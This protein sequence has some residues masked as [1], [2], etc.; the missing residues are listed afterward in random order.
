MLHF[1]HKTSTNFTTSH[2]LHGE[3]LFCYLLIYLV[4]YFLTLYI[5]KRRRRWRAWFKWSANLIRQSTTSL[6]SYSVRS[7]VT[8]RRTDISWLETEAAILSV[9]AAKHHRY[10]PGEFLSRHSH[11]H[12]VLRSCP[13][14]L[15]YNY[16]SN[17]DSRLIC[18]TVID[19]WHVKA[20][21]YFAAHWQFA[22]L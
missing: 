6:P 14:S 4:T 7:T 13:N 10:S 15:K 22:P 21:L 2:I 3:G 1:T 12:Q 19:N 8:W 16:L 9:S 20:T 11:N 17:T 18:L 5:Q